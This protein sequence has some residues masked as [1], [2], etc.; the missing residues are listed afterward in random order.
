MNN[1]NKENFIDYESE[2]QEATIIS[3]NSSEYI[4]GCAAC[5]YKGIVKNTNEDRVSIIQNL[6]QK[7]NRAD[8]ENWPRCSFFGIYDGHG[9]SECSSFLQE[10]L[11]GFIIQDEAFPSQP[12]VALTNGF[13]AAEVAF[14]AMSENNA[15][16]CAN[17]VLIIGD[18]LYCANV[19]DSRSLLGAQGCVA[20]LSRDHK[21]TD[22]NE[23]KRVTLAGGTIYQSKRTVTG[24]GGE[25][26]VH[27]GPLRISPGRLSVTRA[28][29]NIQA[30]NPELNGNPQVL[31][32]RPE[33]YVKTLDDT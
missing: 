26:S 32:A 4:R 3:K 24:F 27:Y 21:P 14:L 33:I 8:A 28:F 16:S 9:G 20:R 22:K 17:V 7:S 13:R 10:N 19:G 2:L 11:H 25:V 30:K 5:T 18:K 6:A 1:S 23:K 15:G 31:I 12:E 29:G